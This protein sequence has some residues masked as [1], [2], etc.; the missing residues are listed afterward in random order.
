MHANILFLI[1]HQVSPMSVRLLE[2]IQQIQHIPFDL[3]S[4]IVSASL[5]DPHLLVMTEEGIV[6]AL[7]FNGNN[8]QVRFC[9]VSLS[10]CQL[11]DQTVDSTICRFISL[12]I[13]P[14]VDLSVCRF[15]SLS[16]Y[17]FVDLSV[18]RFI[19]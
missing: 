9:M 7:T 2:G 10:T 3:G 16:I 13:Y 18:C 6:I 14:F 1:P 4:P 11:A 5:A 8:V 12:S 15:I 17:Q 19:S